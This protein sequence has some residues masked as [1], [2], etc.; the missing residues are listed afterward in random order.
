MLDS[1]NTPVN[2]DIPSKTMRIVR[3]DRQLT[4]YQQQ[5]YYAQQSQPERR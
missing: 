4:Q 1:N 3:T 5:P 2:Y